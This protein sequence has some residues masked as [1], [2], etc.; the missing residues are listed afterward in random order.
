MNVIIAG[1]ARDIEKYWEN[2]KKSLDIIIKSVD[3]YLCIIVESN[4][5]D[6][7]L[8]CL[9]NWANNDSK[10]VI[11]SLGKQDLFIRTQRIAEARNTYMN[12]INNNKL[13]NTYDYLLVVDLDDVLN[14]EDNFKEQLNS[15][16]KITDWDAMASNRNDKY[17]DIWALRSKSEILNCDFDCINI[18]YHIIRIKAPHTKHTLVLKRVRIE[19]PNVQRYLDNP[20]ILHKNIP[21]STG[22]IPCTSAFGGMVLYKLNSIKDKLYDGNITCEHLS[23][24][25]DIKMFINSEFIS[26]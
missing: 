1:A 25:K 16:F 24:H 6:N 8:Q 11:I 15:C 12:Y 4:S 19:E 5:T 13:Y 9:N 23:F 17:Y 10:K 14:I 20:D 22:F 26:G 2:T 21:R 7:S 18:K 3:N